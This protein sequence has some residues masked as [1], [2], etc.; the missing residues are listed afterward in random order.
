MKFHHCFASTNLFVAAL[1]ILAGSVTADENG[2]TIE[3]APPTWDLSR[4]SEDKHLALAK[5]EVK[6]D[7]PTIIFLPI[8][9]DGPLNHVSSTD[10]ASVRTIL[11]NCKTLSVHFYETYGVRNI[12]L[13]GVSKKVADFYNKPETKWQKFTW[14]DTKMI[15]Y[16]TWGDILSSKRWNLAPAFDQKPIGPLTLLGREYSGRIHEALKKSKEQGWFQTKQGF[17]KNQAA[18]TE[19]INKACDG[20]NAKLAKILENDPELKKEYEI[21]VTQR[22]KIFLDNL[23]AAEGPGVLLCGAGHYHD[24]VA[25]LDERNASYAVAVPSGMSWPPA[26]KDDATIFADMREL[27]C[28]LKEVNLGFGDGGSAKIKFPID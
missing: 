25:Q 21:T 27:G 1:W 28:Q 15:T 26:K 16:D 4:L 3:K 22:N 6:G 8:I 20:Y 18:F 5:L 14:G 23:A 17:V 2:A 9:H 13:E 19:L 11:G 10:M 12:L 7:K 24:L